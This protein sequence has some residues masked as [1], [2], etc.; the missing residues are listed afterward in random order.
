MMSASFFRMTS[1]T[2]KASA[3]RW[4]DSRDALD[5]AAELIEAAGDIGA[6]GNTLWNYPTNEAALRDA[7]AAARKVLALCLR[8]EE[9]TT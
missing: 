2:P 9:I 5:L 4:V 8:I 6:S 7:R 1:P 3:S